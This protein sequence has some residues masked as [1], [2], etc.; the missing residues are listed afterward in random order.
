MASITVGRIA[1]VQAHINEAVVLTSPRST[2]SVAEQDRLLQQSCAEA[3]ELLADWLSST[4]WTEFEA[5]PDGPIVECVAGREDFE[6]FLD[7]M[8]KDALARVS[9]EG[10][11]APSDLVDKARMA[12][13]DIGR[14]HRKMS[15]AELFKEAG[16]RV[17]RLQVE[18]CRLADS[19]GSGTQDDAGRRRARSALLK[20]S[21]VLVHFA[22]A[23]TATAPKQAARS[24]GLWARSI[25]AAGIAKEAQPG[26]SI[27]P[28]S[29]GPTIR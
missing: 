6:K 2:L 22:V 27:S 17:S 9:C 23:L 7:P 10:M 28:P 20:V 26:A 24:I 25:V 3:C 15:R 8:F 12:V 19:F 5:G 18:V 16:E 11:N 29:A 1:V 4:W 14:R 13:A 21:N